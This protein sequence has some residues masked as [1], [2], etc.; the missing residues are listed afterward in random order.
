M[1][2]K[3]LVSTSIVG[4]LLTSSIG[5][6]EN[7]IISA[8]TQN[9]DNSTGQVKIIKVNDAQFKVIPNEDAEGKVE[10]GKATLINKKTGKTEMLP[11]EVQVKDNQTANVTYK[12]VDN[13]IIGNVQLKESNDSIA[14]RK[15]NWGKCALGTGSGLI[16]GGGGVA[17]GAGYGAIGA[18]PVSVGAGSVIGG[19]IGGV[20][21]AMGGAAASCFD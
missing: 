1:Y 8:Q 12:V 20:S 6:S 16:G 10:N 19:V 3:I 15:T 4:V 17:T 14:T 9:I 5:I 2:K 11:Q 13:N 7:S 21:G 18:T